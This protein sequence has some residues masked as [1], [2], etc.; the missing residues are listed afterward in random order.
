MNTAAN[1]WTTQGSMSSIDKGS[2][3]FDAA[4]ATSHSDSATIVVL[5][6]PARTEAAE[7]EQLMERV[8]AAQAAKPAARILVTLGHGCALLTPQQAGAVLVFVAR[9]ANAKLA[10]TLALDECGHYHVCHDGAD[11]LPWPTPLTAW[12]QDWHH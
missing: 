1:G 5:L 6:D 4:F 12:Q 3:A 7:C 9:I 2:S 11:P 8:R 10:E